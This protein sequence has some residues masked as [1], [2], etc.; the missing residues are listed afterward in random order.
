MRTLLLL[1]FVPARL[2]DNHRLQEQPIPFIAFIDK[3]KF[4]RYKSIIGTCSLDIITHF[5]F[6]VFI[7]LASAV[8]FNDPSLG[9]RRNRNH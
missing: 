4:V 5:V 6:R 7:L 9:L 2:D 1:L 3:A 8:I